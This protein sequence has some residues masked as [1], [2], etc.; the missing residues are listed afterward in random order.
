MD[1]EDRYVLVMESV[2]GSLH[3][4]SRLIPISPESSPKRALA[5]VLLR[6]RVTLAR[7]HER[8]RASYDLGHRLPEDSYHPAQSMIGRARLENLRTCVETALRNGIPGHLIE[9]GVW[10]GGATIVMKACLVAHGDTERCVYVADSFAGLPAAGPD[11][12]A[13]DLHFDETLAVSQ[14]QVRA[15]FER[16]GLLDDRVVFLEGWFC[17]TLPTVSSVPWAVVR[18]D[19][20]QYGS[21]M[22]GLRN[23][24]PQLSPGG[25]LIVDDFGAYEA[26][27]RAV[28]EYRDEFGI[29]EEIVD[30]DG[31]GVFW[32]KR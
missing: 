30:V 4:G 23:L 21:T 6:R 17:D 16:Y 1:L 26:C 32:R 22:D 28:G 13:A 15:N 11:D 3:P 8:T 20:D 5:Q 12:D 18:L 14:A 24:Y 10:R 7:P 25:F 31:I 19:G 29:T 2:N 27:R 9:T